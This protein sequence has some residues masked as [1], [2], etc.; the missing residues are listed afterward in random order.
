MRKFGAVHLS[1]FAA[2]TVA[3]LGVAGAS[4]EAGAATGGTIHI[5]SA[6]Q[7][8]ADSVT[9]PLLVSGAIGDYGTTT[10]QDKN[11]TVDENGSYEKFTLTQG[12]FVADGTSLNKKFEH[13]KPTFD[14]TNCSGNFSVSGPIPV[15]QGTGAY[16]G[17]KGTLRITI[18]DAFIEPKTSNGK[19]SQDQNATPVSE[20]STVTGSGRVSF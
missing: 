18:V 2:L 5:W 4:S 20:Y 17:I 9:E 3:V 14:K 8:T 7:S 1:A 19:C 16:A 12:T 6:S 15:S 10:S 11:G 13:L